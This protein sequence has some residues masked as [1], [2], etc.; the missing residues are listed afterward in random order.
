M[1][2]EVTK[3]INTKS[4]VDGPSTG[5]DFLHGHQNDKEI[6]DKSVD[7]LCHEFEYSILL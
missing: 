4:E 1:A 2:L 3:S 6:Q 7:R 5:E